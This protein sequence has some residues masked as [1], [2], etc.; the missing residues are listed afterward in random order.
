MSQNYPY[1]PGP[2]RLKGD[3]FGRNL[4]PLPD[5]PFMKAS[6]LYATNNSFNLYRLQNSPP[7]IETVR[8]TVV[9]PVDVGYSC[10]SQ[11]VIAQVD[12]G[13]PYL[14]GRTVFIK[15]YDPLYI[16]PDCL[17]TIRIP[18][19][20]LS[21]TWA[22]S[23]S[24]QAGQVEATASDYPVNDGKNAKEK[25]EQFD[26]FPPTASTSK[27]SGS[28]DKS[29]GDTSSATEFSTKRKGR[30]I[31]GGNVDNTGDSDVT[32]PSSNTTAPTSAKGKSSLTSTIS[33]NAKES[34]DNAHRHDASLVLVT[35]LLCLTCRGDFYGMLRIYWNYLGVHLKFDQSF[36]KILMMLGISN[37]G[38]KGCWIK[39][40][41]RTATFQ[42]RIA[43]LSS[44]PISPRNRYP[45]VLGALLCEILGPWAASDRTHVRTQILQTVKALYSH[46]VYL[47]DISPDNFLVS[48]SGSL[49][50][51]GFGPSYDPKARNLADEEWAGQANRR[52]LAVEDIREELGLIK[53]Q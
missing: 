38:K 40:G 17:Q 32:A 2:S 53:M 12:E 8:V 41:M 35:V 9:K 15:F 18:P 19:D 49:R 30:E 45:K 33:K 42:R 27:I 11:S 50:M 20:K 7:G 51:I 3:Y 4:P 22:L 13:P 31:F 43:S 26:N 6:K 24:A 1:P 14:Q 52:L 16:N 28:V 10:M 46:D 37:H 25:V 36:S 39:V 23:S 34:S 44:P 47:P 5:K 48:N 29:L 21:L